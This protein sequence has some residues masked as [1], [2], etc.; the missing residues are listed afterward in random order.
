MEWRDINR[1]AVERRCDRL[2]TSFGEAPIHERHDTPDPDRF[3]EWLR[4]SKD[5][6]IGSAYALVRRPAADLPP[7]TESMDVEGEEGERVLLILGRGESKW[8]VPGGGQET[9]EPMEATVRREVAEEVGIAISLRGINHMRHEIATCEGYDERLH[10][11]RV[12]FH[13]DYRDGSITIES[14][15]LNGAAWFA[16]PPTAERLLP[17]TQRLLEG[18]S[19]D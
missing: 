3:E 18:W 1:K 17:S 6:Y 7:L 15:E 5:G 19:T 4:L 2:I 10:V 13:A 9:D 12:F 16:T 11:L 14:G 8:G